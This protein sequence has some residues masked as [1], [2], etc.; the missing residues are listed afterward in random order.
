M[1][2][3]TCDLDHRPDAHCHC[4]WKSRSPVSPFWRVETDQEREES[5][6]AIRNDPTYSDAVK[7]DD[8][9]TLLA[10]DG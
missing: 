2:G 3:Y 8:G 5:H 6:D 9:E 1:T 7:E 10:T 4:P